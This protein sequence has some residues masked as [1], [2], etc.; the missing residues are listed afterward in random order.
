MSRTKKEKPTKSSGDAPEPPKEKKGKKKGTSSEGKGQ[1]KSKKDVKS[2]T[3]Q[4][5]SN[6]TS[7]DPERQEDQVHEEQ[8]TEEEPSIM[9]HCPL[10]HPYYDDLKLEPYSSI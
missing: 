1:K 7:E 5:A 9:E 10:W 4:E 8:E 3:S 2:P 6:L